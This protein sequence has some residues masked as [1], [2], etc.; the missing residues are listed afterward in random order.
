MSLFIEQGLRILEE[1]GN[2]TLIDIDGCMSSSCGDGDAKSL[3][4]VGVIVSIVG[5][6]SSNF[7]VNTQKYSMMQEVKNHRNRSYLRQPIWMLGLFLVFLG[8]IAD[9]GA[10]GFAAQSLITPVGGF[11]MVANLFFAS[12]WLGETITKLDIVSTS[13]IIFGIVLVAA[14]AD[15][16]EQCFTLET[17]VCLYHRT[18]FILYA[19]FTALAIAVAYGMVWYIRRETKN[20]KEGEC[21]LPKF[22]RMRT[23]FPVLCATL[24]GLIGAQSV[25]FA[26]STIEILKAVMR[27]DNEFTK[28]GTYI[29]ILMMFLCIFGQIHWLAVGLRDYDAVIMVPLFQ[30]VYVVFTIIGGASY[31]AEFRGFNLLQTIFFPIGVM[32]I[33]SGV[34][35]LAMHKSRTAEDLLEEHEQR[36]G[37]RT[38]G[39]ADYLSDEF[40]SEDESSIPKSSKLGI[41]P[42]SSKHQEEATP[43]A[44]SEDKRTRIKSEADDRKRRNTGL[45]T[46]RGRGESTMSRT[47]RFSVS[48]Q[49]DFNNLTQYGAVAGVYAP[50]MMLQES[51]GGLFHHNEEGQSDATSPPPRRASRRRSFQLQTRK[52]LPS[53]EVDLEAATAASE[54]VRSPPASG[55]RKPSPSDIDRL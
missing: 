46:P 24:S 9:F 21:E 4:Y 33:C 22:R 42:V 17:L 23:A 7:G 16:S 5:S 54:G 53:I 36:L 26:K 31:F 8:A 45:G 35:G 27:G 39:C 28:P 29:I 30:C 32:L 55:K 51:V 48:N 19:C 2:V 15:K 40:S 38:E 20:M 50:V 14:F 43:N 34:M 13:L 47:R 44:P 11:T 49:D 25:L 18:Q 3:W 10:L 37:S 12:Y 1:S 41:L 52:S 6:V